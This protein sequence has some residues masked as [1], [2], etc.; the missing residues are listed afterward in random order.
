LGVILSIEKPD[1][2]KDIVDAGRA[3]MSVV[4]YKK[5]KKKALEQLKL[6]MIGDLGDLVGSYL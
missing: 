1:M 2:I 3:D 6:K 4:K 5:F